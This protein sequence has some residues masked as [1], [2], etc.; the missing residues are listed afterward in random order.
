MCTAK[1][2][3]MGSSF[4][5]CFAGWWVLLLCVLC[6][7]PVLMCFFGF[8]WVG[9]FGWVPLLLLVL[10][11]L[12]DISPSCWPQCCSL[13]SFSL[14]CLPFLSIHSNSPLDVCFILFSLFRWV[15]SHCSYLRWVV[16]PPLSYIRENFSNALC[17]S[18]SLE[19]SF[20]PK[21]ANLALSV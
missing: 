7:F 11:V 16:S 14:L 19:I 20:F 21:Y 18:D 4:C 10:F 9:F 5:S 6:I 12:C 2:F 15:L 8:T 17:P 13:R 3:S 1:T